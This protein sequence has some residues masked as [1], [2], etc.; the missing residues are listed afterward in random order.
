M[1]DLGDAGAV[2]YVGWK[3]DVIS[4]SQ[5]IIYKSGE[6]PRGAHLQEDPDTVFIHFFDGLSE[7]YGT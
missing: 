6:I 7:F 5:N 3:G 1:V 2:L 4:T